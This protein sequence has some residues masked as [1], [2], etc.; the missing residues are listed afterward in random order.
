MNFTA[1]QDFSLSAWFKKSSNGWYGHILKK[2]SIDPSWLLRFNNNNKLYFLLETTGGVN[3]NLESTVAV[4]DTEWHHVVAVADRSSSLK[5]Y[6]DGVL[7]SGSSGSS[8]FD[9]TNTE[10]LRIGTKE[11]G[12]EAFNGEISNVAVY[13]SAL[14]SS[15]VSTLLNFGTPE[16]AISFSP[17][18]WWKLDNTTTGIQD[19]SG[20]GNNGTNNGAAEVPSGVAVTPSWKIPTALPIPSINYS[21]SL[22]FDPSGSGD[23][24]SFGNRSAFQP[25]SSYTFSIWFNADSSS[26]ALF[27]TNSGRGSTGV[28]ALLTTTSIFYHHGN[29]SQLQIAHGGLNTWHNFTVTW[30]SSTGILRAFIDGKYVSQKVGVNSIT[31]SS[32]LEVGRIPANNWKYDGK[33]SN[34][35]MWDTALTD[36]FSGTPSGVAGGQVP[37]RHRPR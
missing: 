29:Q 33:L 28:H 6:L 4:T 5:I 10:T 21:K 2:G 23:Y 35:A 11:D 32:D 7:V 16:T 1:N 14:T 26:Y 18:A 3:T 24:I 15:Q 17:E 25:T 19:S 37:Q 9:V 20:N 27:G 30:S 22:D 36:G 34:F 12:S 8:S 31:W 13:N